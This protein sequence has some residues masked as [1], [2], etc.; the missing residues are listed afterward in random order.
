MFGLIVIEVFRQMTVTTLDCTSNDSMHS[1]TSTGDWLDFQNY[2]D[3]FV[4]DMD[5]EIVVRTNFVE[6]F[7]FKTLLREQK[8]L[9]MPRFKRNFERRNR[10]IG[11]RE[12]RIGLK[13]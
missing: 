6:R 10:L 2:F 1:S 13:R 7:V 12:K 5:K 4:F 8:K 11:K 3:V 9:C